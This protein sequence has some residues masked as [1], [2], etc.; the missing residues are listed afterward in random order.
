L[1]LLAITAS[2]AKRNKYVESKHGKKSILGDTFGSRD[3]L[4]HRAFTDETDLKTIA[5]KYAME[6]KLPAEIV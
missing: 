5:G 2:S 6:V 3:F 4:G 1:L